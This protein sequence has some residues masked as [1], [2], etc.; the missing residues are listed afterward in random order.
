MRNH[1]W[2]LYLVL[3]TALVSGC[4][5]ESAT[6]ENT[7]NIE[8]QNQVNSRDAGSSNGNV[9]SNASADKDAV[10]TFTDA[11]EALKKGDEYLESNKTKSA[12]EALKQSTELDPDLADA[13][14]KL[15][16]AF[17]LSESVDES[18]TSD[19]NGQSKAGKKNSEKSFENAIKAY[20]KLIRSDRKNHEAYYN[21]GRA[22]NK[23][24]DDSAAAKALQK[25]VDLN[26][27]DSLYRTEL[28]AALIKMAKYSLAVK[29]LNKAIELDADNFRA[30]DLLAK[31]E[32]GK[33]RT[34][35]KAKPKKTKKP[36]PKPKESKPVPPSPPPPAATVKPAN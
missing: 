26:P 21:M 6:N 7:G 15:G 30:E 12:I 27:D 13:H 31:A 1:K 24:Y 19:D 18:E 34:N 2:H 20:K 23:L 4:V 36:A 33:K 32:A 28:G 16:V 11:N 29:Q 25:A 10:P 14:F 5:F 17:S 22:H 9:D 35:F 3:S 8:N